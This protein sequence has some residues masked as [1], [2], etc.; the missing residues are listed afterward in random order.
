MY[1]S[2]PTKR[3]KNESMTQVNTQMKVIYT[4]FLGK[5]IKH[6]TNLCETEIHTKCWFELE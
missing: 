4:L 3:N 5:T 1:E 6:E 2:W